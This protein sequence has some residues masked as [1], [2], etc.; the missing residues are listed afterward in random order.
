MCRLIHKYL[1]QNYDI[2]WSFEPGFYTGIDIP[3]TENA[4]LLVNQVATLHSH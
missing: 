4:C 2:Q 1:K 3:D